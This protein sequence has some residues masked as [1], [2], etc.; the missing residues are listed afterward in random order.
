MK[1]VQ[2]SLGYGRQLK[3]GGERERKGGRKEG[4]KDGN[5]SAKIIRLM[6]KEF[7]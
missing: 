1:V 5:H 3:I 7:T 2:E 4:R 6:T